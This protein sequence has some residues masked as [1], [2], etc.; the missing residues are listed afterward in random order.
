MRNIWKLAQTKTETET[1]P[2]DVGTIP[3]N[4][5]KSIALPA[6]MRARLNR[7]VAEVLKPTYFDKIPLGPV[8]EALAKLNIQVIQEDGTPWSGFL[9]GGKR[10]GDPQASSQHADFELAYREPGKN[11]LLV[12]AVLSLSWCKMPSENYEVVGY[13]S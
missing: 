7:A 5:D 11:G 3:V 9:M 12:N 13:I 8:F 2:I 1:D 6:S 4:M 10:C